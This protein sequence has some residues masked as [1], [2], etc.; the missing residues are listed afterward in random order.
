[1]NPLSLYKK[2]GFLPLLFALSFLGIGIFHTFAACLLSLALLGWLTARAVKEKQICLPKNFI[3]AAV[4]VAVLFY[5]L[6][7]FWAV[8]PGM[9]FTGF[10]KFLPVFLFLIALQQERTAGP[11]ILGLLPYLSTVAT[12]LSAVGMQIPVLKNFFAVDGRLAG[13]L[14]YP[15]TFALVL[16]VSE[17]LIL[18]KEKRKI[19]DFVCLAVLIFGLFYTG[20]RTVFVLAVLANLCVLILSKNTKLKLGVACGMGAVAVALGVYALC[21]GGLGVFGRFLTI[22]LES[23]TFLGRFLY[24]QDAL[25]VILKHPFGL[26]YAGYYYLQQSFQTGVYSVMFIHNDF[27]QLLLDIGWLPTLLFAVAV[28]H[29]FWKATTNRKIILAVF[30]L[31]GCFDFNLQFVTI[32]VL[33]LLFTEYQKGQQLTIKVPAATGI[34]TVLA[35]LCL[36]CGVALGLADFGQRNP[37]HALYP[38]N[39]PNETV[40]LTTDELDAANRRADRILKQ[41][42]YVTLAHSVKARFAYSKGDFTKVITHKNELFNIAPFQYAEYEEYCYMLINGI[43]LY[44]RNGDTASANICKKELLNTQVRVQAQQDRLSKLGTKIGDQP[45]TELPKDIQ[46]YIAKLEGV[47]S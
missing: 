27:L 46:N 25:P 20:S 7:T 8:D 4:A 33:L 11:K 32:F 37:A 17:L 13:F 39:T 44:Q 12:V 43:T 19:Y 29:A 24:F 23:S 35:A 9:A 40:L 15:N 5:G 41:N 36:Y 2:I 45:T 6:T 14:Q 28:F 21:A 47:R 42:P 38:W 30:L 34:F 3:T 1:M 31:H 18:G 26:G 16:L 22:S 10:L